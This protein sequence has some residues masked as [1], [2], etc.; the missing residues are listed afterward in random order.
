MNRPRVVILGG[1]FGGVYT[2]MHL[3]KL[4]PPGAID[5]TLVSRENHF[6]FTPMLHEVAASDLDVTHIV[7]PIR[8]L[9]RRG[10]V[11]AGEVTEI[12]LQRKVVEVGHRGGAHQHI[13]PYDHLVIA[14]GSVTNFFKLPGLDERALT[15]KTL[16]DA[17]A[18]RNRAIQLL[19][20]AEFESSAV[21]RQHLLTF[22]VAGGGFAGVETLAALNDFLRE[23]LQ[24]YPHI[25]ES[26]L[27]LV[28]VEPGPRLLPELD[29][30]LGEYAARELSRRGVEVCIGVGVKAASEEGVELS[31][32][33]TVAAHTIVWTAGTAGHPLLNQLPCARDRGRVLVNESLEVAEWPGV[34]ALGDCALV[35]NSRTGKPHPPT[36]QHAI[37]QAKIAAWNIRASL[38]GEPRKRFEFQGLGQLA[39]IGRRT[40][41]AQILGFQFS[42]F[43][44]WLFWR[45]IYLAKL[46]RLERKVRVAI[47]WTL[48]LFFT[49]DIVQFQTS[50]SGGISDAPHLE[51]GEDPSLE[52]APADAK[53][54]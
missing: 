50:R 21:Q 13:I 10:V 5:L 38:R 26:D 7:N 8:K 45:S 31:D 6:L 52:Y 49:K 42:G 35:P 22:L 12:D 34:W 36:A 16:G 3:E 14:L 29:D 23:S 19:E 51:P 20:E 27:R 41:V 1:G 30:S 44:A 43:V 28:L 37:R 32:G 47:D 2:A 33:E 24:F 48:D 53:P 25:K 11:V 54:L 40:G 17:L 39:A 18:L 9:V 4:M 46:P 15:M